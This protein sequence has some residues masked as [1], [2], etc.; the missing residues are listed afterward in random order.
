MTFKAAAERFHAIK[1]VIHSMPP[2]MRRRVFA[3]DKQRVRNYREKV[4]AP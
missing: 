3:G 4:R 2:E 1:D